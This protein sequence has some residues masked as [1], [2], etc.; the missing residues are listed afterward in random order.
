MMSC[1]EVD[2]GFDVDEFISSLPH[3]NDEQ[4]PWTLPQHLPQE[5]PEEGEG[6]HPMCELG[7]RIGSAGNG[8]APL[9]EFG[10]K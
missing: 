5:P 3:E 10:A 4:R 9:P 7:L 6:H 8:G 1:D 2:I